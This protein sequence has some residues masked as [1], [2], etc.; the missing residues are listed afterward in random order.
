MRDIS[1]TTYTRVALFIFRDHIRP[2]RF[3]WTHIVC[4]AFIYLQYMPQFKCINY[5]RLVK[6]MNNSL[7]LKLTI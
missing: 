3:I 4:N 5:I 1:A 7:I 6:K 2:F